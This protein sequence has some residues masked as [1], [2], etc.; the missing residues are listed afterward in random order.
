MI[1]KLN[2]VERPPLFFEQWVVTPSRR[3]VGKQ[4][5]TKKRGII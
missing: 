5:T 2:F 3:D 4:H 1:G